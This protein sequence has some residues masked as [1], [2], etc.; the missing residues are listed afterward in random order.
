VYET[1]AKRK[2]RKALEAARRK[3]AVEAIRPANGL[4]VSGDN[5]VHVV[6]FLLDAYA[7]TACST[8]VL[9]NGLRA[10]ADGWEMGEMTNKEVNCL[11]CLT[12]RI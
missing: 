9:L 8:L 10:Y 7:Y 3:E 2:K 6:K 5:G 12:R 1:R 4:N 11:F